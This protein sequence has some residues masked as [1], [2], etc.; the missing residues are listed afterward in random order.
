[1]LEH[2]HLYAMYFYD[3]T[4]IKSLGFLSPHLYPGAA[5][6]KAAVVTVTVNANVIVNETQCLNPGLHLLHRVS[7]SSSFFVL[8]L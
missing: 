1:V 3:A 4:G 5:T 6:Y 2:Q 7:R 8:S